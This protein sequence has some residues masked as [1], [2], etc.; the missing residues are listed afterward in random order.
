MAEAT[1]LPEPMIVRVG[2]GAVSFP[3]ECCCC[4]APP[5]HEQ[6]I[7]RK[8]T[9]PLGIARITRTVTLSV[10]CCAKCSRNVRW[11]AG[12]DSFVGATIGCAVL[13]LFVGIIPGA[14]IAAFV[15]VGES[16]REIIGFSVAIGLVVLW[17]VFR[18]RRNRGIPIEGHICSTI[19]PAGIAGFDADTTTLA[20]RNHEFGGKV[21]AMNAAPAAQTA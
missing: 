5:D 19:S 6:K 16:G 9:I 2:K 10:P 4:G 3:R 21:A 11:H 7:E 20:F 12:M 15:P 8:K 18:I 14:I 17:L 13:M 1:A